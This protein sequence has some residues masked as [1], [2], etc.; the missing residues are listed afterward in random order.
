MN[1]SHEACA[2]TIGHQ[3]AV[4]RYALCNRLQRLQV[5]DWGAIGISDT[6]LT[7]PRVDKRRFL[8]SERRDSG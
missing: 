5:S 6:W 2:R 1:R 4:R 7:G 3:Q 8:G